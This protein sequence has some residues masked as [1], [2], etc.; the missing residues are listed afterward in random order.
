MFC[1]LVGRNAKAYAGSIFVGIITMIFSLICFLNGSSE[2]HNFSML[3]GMFCGLGSVATVLGII[4][5]IHYKRTPAAKLKQEEIELKDERNVEILRIAY[6]VSSSAASILFAV[7][8]FVF[9]GLNYIMPSFICVGAL[10]IQILVFL[11]AHRYFSKK[12]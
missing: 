8:A 9:V 11:I 6:T 12:M 3:M 5:L 7:M 4:R 1:R 2:S 10:W